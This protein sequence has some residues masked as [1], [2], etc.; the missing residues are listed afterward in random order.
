MH[1]GA[2]IYDPGL[3][4]FAQADTII[5][6]LRNPAD[7]DRYSYVRNS[8][9]KYSDPNGPFPWIP[10]LIAGTAVAAYAYASSIGLLPDIIG[11]AKVYAA[12]GSNGISIEVAAGLAVQGEYAGPIDDLAG[13]LIAG[14]SG[15][16]LAQTGPKELS[17]RGFENADP[18]DP[19][20]A[21]QV[22]QARIK[23][24]QS[25]CA[26]CDNF[27]KLVA[28]GIGQ[29]GYIDVETIGRGPSDGWQTILNITEADSVGQL[30]TFIDISDK[31][32]NA[33]LLQKY[34]KDLRALYW[35]GWDLPVGMNEDD[36][37]NYLNDM[38]TLANGE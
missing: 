24:A 28:A 2:R 16:G 38:E 6:Q 26:G 22:M 13:N 10:L 37:D 32:Y 1:Y 17:A 9:V 18:H 19:A 23:E 29:N 14:D 7:W 31:K 3:G 4:R 27:N 11:I 33:I 8:P 25:A 12:V 34:A 15:Y 30:R 20:V 35:L 36:F 5:P 21:I